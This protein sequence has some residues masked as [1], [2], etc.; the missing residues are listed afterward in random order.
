VLPCSHTLRR[1]W[2]TACHADLRFKARWV[3]VVS[4]AWQ[5]KVHAI[6]T[7]RQAPSVPTR[8]SRRQGSEGFDPSALVQEIVNADHGSSARQMLACLTETLDRACDGGSLESLEVWGTTKAP[9][10][11]SRLL[12]FSHGELVPFTGSAEKGGCARRHVSEIRPGVGRHS[13][14]RAGVYLRTNV[15]CDEY[16]LTSLE[17]RGLVSSTSTGCSFYRGKVGVDHSAVN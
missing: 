12:L 9:L 10:Q 16:L 13:R 3:A 7:S 2:T 8:W 14:T 5:H 6:A 1:S 17:M 4:P 15:L 11:R